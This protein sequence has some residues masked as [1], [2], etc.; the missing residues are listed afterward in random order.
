MSRL[1]ATEIAQTLKSR[2]DAGEWLDSRIPPE[3]D[4]AE[5]FGVARNTIRR[6]MALLKQDGAIAGHVGRGTYIT[7][8]SDAFGAVLAR[9]RNGSPADMM[10]LRMMLEPHAAAM[11][12][13]TATGSQLKAVEEAHEQAVRATEMA[14]FEHWDAEF[15]HRIFACSRNELL[16]EVHNLLRALRNQTAWFEMKKRSFSEQRRQLYCTEHAALFEAL[17]RRDPDGAQRAM[18]DHLRTV[19]LN[20]LGR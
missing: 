12:A 19:S 7:P 20:L 18:T 2:I 8:Q 1:A 4:L 10:E 14:G 3:R 16:K 6:A 15:H 11:A 13:T 9:M 17:L 5:D